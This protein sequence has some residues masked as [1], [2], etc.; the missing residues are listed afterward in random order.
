M[1]STYSRSTR[2][3]TAVLENSINAVEGEKLNGVSDMTFSLPLN[4]A[5]NKYCGYLERIRWKETGQLYRILDDE[6]DKIEG[7]PVITYSAEHVIATLIDDVIFGTF[8]IDN[9]TTRQSIER[10]LALQTTRNWMLGDCDFARYFS[11]NWSNENLLAALFSIPNRFDEEYKWIFD[12]SVYPWVLHLKK[13]DQTINPEFYVRNGRNLLSANK[14]NKGREICTRLYGLG[15]GEGVN[16]LTFSSVNSGK[17]YIDAEPEAIKKYGLITRIWEDLRFEDPQSLLDRARVLLKGYSKPYESYSVQVADIEKLSGEKYDRAEAGKIVW[18]EGYKTYITQVERHLQEVGQDTLE[19]ANAPMDVASS[20]ADL[21]DRQ[22][23][24][25]VY[26]QGATCLYSQSFNDNADP[27]HPATLQFYVPS[28]ARQINKVI[29]SWRLEKFRAYNTGAESTGTTTRS[30]SAGGKSTRTSSASGNS[31]ETSGASSSNTTGSEGSGLLSTSTSAQKGTGTSHYHTYSYAVLPHEHS[32]GH[33]HTFKT[34]SHTHTVDIPEHSHT[35]DIPGHTHALIFGIYEGPR[36][37]SAT[38]RVDGVNVPL[39]TG[40]TEI[41]VATKLSVESGS[42][43]IRRGTF[44]TIEIIPDALTRI[45][46]TISMQ[47]FIQSEG[48]GLY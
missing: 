38:L 46:A 24:N 30:T 34:P 42:G 10:V 23:I 47:L 26:A 44:H 17:P 14:L 35:I 21:A 20:I 3:K 40:Q 32:M 1:L 37:S 4:D 6:E 11:Y 9:L 31:S 33:T 27:T 19:L 25:S 45:S 8:Q 41:D 43:K 28:E 18:F 48:G 29:L 22:R 15:Y 36:A 7:V 12:T 16:Q 2:L 13:L 5:K 39:T